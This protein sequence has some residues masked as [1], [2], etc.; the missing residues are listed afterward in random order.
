MESEKTTVVTT[1][2]PELDLVFMCDCTGSMGSYIESAKQ[3]IRSIIEAVKA[4]EKRDVRFALVLYKDFNDAFVSKKYPWTTKTSEAFSYVSEMYADGGGDTPEAVA[5]ALNDVNN[6]EYR[7]KAVRICVLVADAPPH[8][9]GEPGDSYPDRGL[10]IMQIANDMVT[11]EIIVYSVGVEP[12]LG[13]SR[14]GRDFYKALSSMTG[15]KYIALG[16]ANLLPKVIVGGAE[17]ELKME[18]LSEAMKEEEATIRAANS[19]ITEEDLHK[20]IA[21]NLAKKGIKC[22]TLKVTDFGDGAPTEESKFIASCKTILEVRNYTAGKMPVHNTSNA[23]Y[24]D[25]CEDNC[26]DDCDD[27]MGSRAPAKV[28]SHA[29]ASGIVPK[30]KPS[31]EHQTAMHDDCDE[32]DYEKVKRVMSRKA[33]ATNK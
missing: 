19:N 9:I 14:W 1:D 4:S 12:Q 2:V 28:K 26:D 3:N 6:L 30:A 8:G 23:I 16:Q 33:K 10:D 20:C 22:T 25:E 21:E 11:K 5:E 32:M 24:E 17:E 7:K 29:K 27:D 18:K 15:G 13:S 31:Y